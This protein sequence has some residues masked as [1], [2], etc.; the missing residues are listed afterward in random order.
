MATSNAAVK[1]ATGKSWEQWFALLDEAGAT[2]LDHKKMAAW[3]HKHCPSG[4]WSQMIAVTYQQS[5]G[6]R[7]KFQT[8]AGDFKANISKTFDVSLKQLF[9]AWEDAEQRMGWMNN[10]GVTVRRATKDKSMRITWPDKTW[11]DVYFTSKGKNKA[12]VAVDHSKLA[13]PED[14]Q[15]AKANWTRSFEDLRE[16][17]AQQG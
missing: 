13:S 15:R 14:V 2:K 8:S 7:K 11:V 16:W 3:I 6:L 9:C 17:L 10:P 1:K 12:Q 5:R 4:W